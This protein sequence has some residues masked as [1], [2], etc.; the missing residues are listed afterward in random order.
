MEDT[1]RRLLAAEEQ[2]EA[3]VQRA[4]LERDRLIAQASEEARLA[5]QRFDGRLGELRASFTDKAEERAQETLAEL[6]R[7]YGERRRS[8]ENQ[9]EERRPAAGDAALAVLLGRVPE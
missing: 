8:L 7:R 6:R 4:L 2:A 1:L 5:E 9:V 3:L